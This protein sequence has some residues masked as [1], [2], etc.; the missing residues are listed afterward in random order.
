MIRKLKE[1]VGNWVLV[2]HGGKRIL[3]MKCISFAGISIIAITLLWQLAPPLFMSNIPKGTITKSDTPLIKDKSGTKQMGTKHKRQNIGG[4]RDDE[5]IEPK[6][7]V[8]GRH[9]EPIRYEGRQVFYPNSNT[10]R[11]PSGA[12]F[13]GKLL[14]SI[15]TRSQQRVHVTLPYGG[16]HKSGGGSFP[17]DTILMGQFNYPGQDERV[18]IT[19]NRAVTPDGLEIAI[20]AQA[21]SSKD[22]RAGLFGDYHSNKGSRMASVIGLS[23]VGG[24]SEI[25]IEKEGF[26]QGNGVAPKATIKNGLYNG[27]T[28]VT[29]SEANDQATQLGQSPNYV[30]IDSGADLIISLE[31]GVSTSERHE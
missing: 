10:E 3:N 17:P 6:P 14:T 8:V 31:E 29:E 27:I 9:F 5:P 15:D 28:K 24:I 4:I 16:S 12:K 23:M 1:Y 7:K 30:T 18:F 26:G 22:Y 11:I 21:L 13:I 19:F 2:V 25:M 20:Q